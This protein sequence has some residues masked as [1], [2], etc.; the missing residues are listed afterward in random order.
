MATYEYQALTG[1]DRLM[2]GTIEAATPQQA[3]QMLG[4]MQ[5]TVNSVEKAPAPRLKTPVGRNEFLLF[6]QQLAAI[7]RAGIP[8]ERG[9]RELAKDIASRS[10]RKLISEIAG[11]L[12]S[13]V[14]IEE[15]FEKR[16]KH[17]PPLYG[18]IL[19]A[20][21]ETGRLSEM[22]TSLNRQL[23]VTNRTRRI[24]FEATCYPLVVLMLAAVIVSAMFLLVIPQFN[25]I[26]LDFGIE[27]PVATKLLL[28]M[29][30]YVVP[31][32]IG[33]GCV[34]GVFILSAKFLSSTPTS[35][36]YKEG[37]LL[38]IPVFGR[39]FLSSLLGRLADA[40]ALLIG[41]GSDMPGC[42]RLAANSTGSEKLKR[43]A[44]MVA[45]QLDE[46]SNIIEAGQLCRL[47]PRLFLYSM[48]LGAQRNELQDNLYSL[49]QM[50]SHQVQCYQGR[51]QALLLP[52]LLVF[53]GGIIAL[54]VISL[55]LPMITMLQSLS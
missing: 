18:Q 46:G 16:Q 2:K 22:L 32:W 45:A 21:V 40:M 26:Y 41:A 11:E 10:M 29:P 50:Y 23:E 13:G 35:R 12:E 52:I 43:E 37:V 4:E 9:L 19:K 34:V 47:I 54:C 44:E 36:M 8:L 1:A 33:L 42:M 5:L 25:E 7:T 14:G 51:L 49:A 31:F 53:L 38:R 24:V 15:A 17:F 39:L 55:F 28:E 6:N 30:Q 48:Q 20:G 27:L 3:A